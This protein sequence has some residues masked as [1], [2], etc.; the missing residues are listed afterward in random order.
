[1]RVDVVEIHEGGR[2]VAIEERR[3]ADRSSALWF[4]VLGAGARWYDDAGG[5]YVGH[6]VQDQ[7]ERAVRSHRG[8][9]SSGVAPPS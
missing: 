2:R 8:S 1:M 7:I 5:G 6:D 3:Y 4:A 9:A